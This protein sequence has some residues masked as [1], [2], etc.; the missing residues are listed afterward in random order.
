MDDIRFSLMNCNGAVLSPRS[1][2]HCHKKTK[3]HRRK[4]M[5]EDTG[6]L[7]LLV[8]WFVTL[9]R[10][11][12]VGGREGHKSSRCNCQVSCEMHMPGSFLFMVMSISY[13]QPLWE[14]LS[15]GNV[16]V[17]CNNYGCTWIAQ[18]CPGTREP[19]ITAKWNNY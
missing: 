11:R 16:S 14:R 19:S 3:C 15:K 18:S 17:R 5:T 8:C 7:I 13:L 12:A 10:K 4:I 1:P 2:F 6:V 9:D